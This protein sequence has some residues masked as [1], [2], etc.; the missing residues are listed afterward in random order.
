MLRKGADRDVNPYGGVGNDPASVDKRKAHPWP[1]GTIASIG[2]KHFVVVLKEN[3]HMGTNRHDAALGVI[4]E[5]D[6]ARV[7]DK[8]Y[9]YNDIINHPKGGPGVD[10]GKLMRDGMDYIRKD[11][12]RTDLILGCSLV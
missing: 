6:M 1:R 7:F 12:P 9:R 11:F 2:G 4:N 10:Q 5:D 8:L 3:K